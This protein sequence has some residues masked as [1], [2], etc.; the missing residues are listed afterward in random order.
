MRVSFVLSEAEQD[1]A[2]L[3]IS[4]VELDD[5]SNPPEIQ[6]WSALCFYF[7]EDGHD[8]VHNLA[9]LAKIR[10]DKALYAYE[11]PTEWST[12]I[13]GTLLL[14]HTAANKLFALG[15]LIYKPNIGSENLVIQPEFGADIDN[16]V[17]YWLMV[18]WLLPE[19][20]GKEIDREKALTRFL[21]NMFC[22]FE[23]W[24]YEGRDQASDIRDAVIAAWVC[25]H[26]LPK[27][28]VGE[29]NIR[30][31]NAEKFLKAYKTL[32]KEY[33]HNKLTR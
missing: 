5:S 18:Q 3:K 11:P 10:C 7:N 26:D 4:D 14:T 22:F 6:P 9:A 31:K 33:S 25:P 17:E 20:R 30:G 13:D 2:N 29:A 23:G 15:E 1:D 27:M 21:N 28:Q 19:I 16:Y 8:D 32:R 24:A 12:S